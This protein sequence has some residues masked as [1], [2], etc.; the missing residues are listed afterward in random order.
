MKERRDMGWDEGS[1]EICSMKEGDTSACPNGDRKEEVERE[2]LRIRKKGQ[3]HR[4]L[5][6][7]GWEGI[8]RRAVEEG[9]AMEEDR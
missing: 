3:S 8:G 4:A 6:L 1:R 2:G 7:R 9:L 5:S